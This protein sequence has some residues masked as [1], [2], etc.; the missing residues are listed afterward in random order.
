MNCKFLHFLCFDVK[1]KAKN[2]N[3]SPPVYGYYH[4]YSLTEVRISHNLYFIRLLS[5]TKCLYCDKKLNSN[6]RQHYGFIMTALGENIFRI[7]L[8]HFAALPNTE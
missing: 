5:P 2:S 7:G 3:N 8:C 1:F 4:G 6:L